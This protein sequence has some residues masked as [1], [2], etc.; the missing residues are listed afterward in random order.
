VSS[1][2]G[3]ERRGLDDDG[4]T[5]FLHFSLDSRESEVRGSSSQ[6]LRAFGFAGL[7]IFRGLSTG[8]L[9]RQL[10]NLDVR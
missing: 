1:L 8:G 3:T 5:K 9:D 2:D 4:L 6:V 10:S 7:G